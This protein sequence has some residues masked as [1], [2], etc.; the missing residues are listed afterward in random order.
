MREKLDTAA[1]AVF[2]YVLGPGTS[3][4]MVMDHH[5]RFIVQL[6][7]SS[8]QHG[9][10]IVQHREEIFDS[11]PFPGRN[12]QHFHFLRPRMVQHPRHNVQHFLPNVQYRSFLSNIL[13]KTFN[14]PFAF[15]GGLSNIST[16]TSNIFKKSS[17]IAWDCPTFSTIC[18]SF[19]N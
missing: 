1:V 5:G 16:L 10:F 9:R 14:I 17:N 13:S 7:W 3:G 18:S 15:P 12:V 19:Q 6:G 2:F 8:V 11:H 4:W